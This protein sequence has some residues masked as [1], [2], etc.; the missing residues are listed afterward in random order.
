[1]TSRVISIFYLVIF[2]SAFFSVGSGT[3]ISADIT[4]AWD[5]PEDPGEVDGY[6]IYYRVGGTGSQDL[7]D[8]TGTGLQ[9]TNFFQNTLP[10][11]SG[12]AIELTELEI[13]DGAV[14]LHIEN[15]NPYAKY[16]FVTTAY[17][18]AGESDPSNE[19]CNTSFQPTIKGDL[20][21]DGEVNL[22]DA[23]IVLKIQSNFQS[24]FVQRDADVN[25]DGFIRGEEAIYI[26]QKVGAIR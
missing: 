24:I 3:A 15:Y 2:L 12:T 14:Y 17:N 19:A 22:E 18:G 5:A 23:I 6:K 1:M 25:G 10:L 16:C 4:L 11:D 26:L 9:Y 13:S 21:S 20:N 8:Y 7:E